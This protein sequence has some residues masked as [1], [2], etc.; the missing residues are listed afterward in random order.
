[1]S[2]VVSFLWVDTCAIRFGIHLT[3]IWGHVV[4]RPGLESLQPHAGDLS[5]HWLEVVQMVLLNFDS[6]YKNTIAIELEYPRKMYSIVERELH[7][8]QCRCRHSWWTK[9]TDT[10]WQYTYRRVES[11]VY[12]TAYVHRV[13]EHDNWVD[14]MCTFCTI[15]YT[16]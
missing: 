3:A 1:M 16:V 4:V 13:R 10:I 5:R 6:P 11:V 14:R 2:S 8:Q 15:P 12:F 7:G 9:W